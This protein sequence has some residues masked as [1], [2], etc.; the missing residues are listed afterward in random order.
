MSFQRLY[1]DI[2]ERVGEDAD[3]LF[4]KE[5]LSK[6][7]DFTKDYRWDFDKEDLVK[8]KV[9]IEMAVKEKDKGTK[10]FRSNQLQEACDV[11]TDYI[12]M[13]H[14]I[15]IEERVTNKMIYQGYANRS[16][17]FFRANRYSQCLDDINA[18]LHYSPNA[19]VDYMIHDRRA[20]CCLFLKS[21]SKARKAFKDALE[22]K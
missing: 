10:F 1:Q 19:K 5:L 16:A 8:D 11:Y 21:W 6:V 12:K 7:H 17:V 3:N 4:G 15:K 9:T 18:A 2:R 13:C 22:G 14:N 20:R